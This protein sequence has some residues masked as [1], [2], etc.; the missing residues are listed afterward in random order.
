L[1]RPSRINFLFS[2][3][4][5][6]HTALTSSLPAGAGNWVSDHVIVSR[7]ICQLQG[8]AGDLAMAE[9]KVLVDDNFHYMD[10]SERYELG[11][12]SSLEEA[13]RVCRKLVDDWL[14]HTYKPGMTADHLYELY[15]FFGE[16][17]FIA[18]PPGAS[19][20]V[21]FSAWNY[22]R[23]RATTICLPPR[24]IGL[25]KASELR[26]DHQYGLWSLVALGRAV[27]RLCGTCLRR[28]QR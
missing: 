21:P 23:E 16:D 24:L 28:I 19:L 9:Y 17:P 10:E 3:V 2:T 27:S 22:A 14:A 25:N 4:Y 26:V 18:G 7:W 5:E 12:Y 1:V 8:A 6:N 20:G 11:R 13:S 15:V